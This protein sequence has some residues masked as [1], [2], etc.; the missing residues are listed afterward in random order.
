MQELEEFRE[1]AK[2]RVS[3]LPV[4]SAPSHPIPLA[5]AKLLPNETPRKKI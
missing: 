2:S 3:G 1:E 5:N 4:S